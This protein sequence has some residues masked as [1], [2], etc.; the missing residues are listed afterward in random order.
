MNILARIN[1]PADVK[2]LS[3]TEL[4]RL[5][6]EVRET[7]IDVTSKNGGHVAPNLGA[8]ELTIALHYVFDAPQDK[9][10]W[11]VGHQC[12]THK[13]LTGRRD[14]FHTLRQ[15]KGIS[16][17]PKRDESEYD[18][19]DT[20]HAGTS[21]SAAFGIAKARDMQGQDFKV[22]PVIGDG[23]AI[24]GMALEAFNHIGD[25][26]SNVMVILNDNAMS[27]GRSTG[28]L[29]N[30][31][32]KI[33]SSLTSTGF[34]QNLRARVWKLIGKVLH[35]RSE[36]WRGWA[37]RWERGIK[38]ILTPGGFFEDMGFHYFGP[39]KGH[40]L[41]ELIKYLK[42][43]KDVPGPK[44]FHVITEKG[45]G[46][47]GAIDDPERF[48]GIGPYDPKTCAVAPSSGQS[49]SNFF[50]CTLAEFA[51][52]DPD[53]VAITAGMTLGT[54]LSVF[55]QAFPDRLFD[56]GISEEHCATF[57]AGL[58]LEGMKPVYAVYS[59]FL[60]RGFDQVI[61]DVALQN[62]PV[63]FAIDRGGVVGAD[64]PTHHGV[65]D[66]SFLRMIPNM[67]VAAPRDEA[68]FKNLLWT[69][70]QHRKG[71]FAIRYPRAKI[72]GVEVP[73]LPH[74][75]PIGSWEI[76][77]Q[78]EKVAI[79]AVGEGVAI[80]RKTLARLGR[81]NPTL[82]D[83]R[84][85]KPLDDKLL[86]KL[87]KTHDALITIEE[88]ALAGGFGSAVLEWLHTAGITMP[89]ERIGLPDRFIEHGSR[90]RL[91]ANCG[92]SV[93]GLIHAVKKVGVRRRQRS[94]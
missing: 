53:I 78:G 35:R 22:V 26:Q 8:V 50:G 62:L 63:V 55:A 77:K 4:E 32:G 75:L 20:G 48:H 72:L 14:R 46:F 88:N 60:Q 61:H 16:G 11:D 43:L 74:K 93:S 87:A 66:L 17:F 38:S 39:V 40:D 37:R 89:V 84:F 83:S 70:L 47:K 86:K 3:I 9:I 41:K 49:Y 80:A 81:I 29:S 56:F 58:T 6:R 1:S 21:L 42:R 5:A 65:F 71:P 25:S 19:F 51:E 57:A 76:L 91:L 13:L 73:P 23:S 54:G 12:Y 24:S 36:F 90:D 68:E 44:L 18:V 67:V 92:V 15:Y 7:I 28:A 69:A 52:K 79:L 33:T 2:K 64:G 10:I 45:H 27:I 59:T 30:Y 85:I 94:R 31:L 82:V 34:Y